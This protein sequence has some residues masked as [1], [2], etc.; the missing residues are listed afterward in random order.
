MSELVYPAAAAGCVV[1]FVRSPSS[2]CRIWSDPAFGRA[3]ARGASTPPVDD[4][5]SRCGSRVCLL[6]HGGDDSSLSNVLLLVASAEA[7]VT[8]AQP[9]GEVDLVLPLA[10][11]P[12]MP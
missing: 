4:A 8:L 5:I 3:A 9:A 7:V 12:D 11:N 1:P 2:L 6:S 10:L